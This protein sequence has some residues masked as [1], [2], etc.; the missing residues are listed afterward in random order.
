VAESSQV[1]TLQLWR[2][3]DTGV[4]ASTAS[5]PDLI[6][7]VDCWIN[8]LNLCHQ[9]ICSSTGRVWNPRHNLTSVFCAH[10]ESKMCLQRWDLWCPVCKAW[11]ILFWQE[12]LTC[13]QEGV[14]I[15]IN[16]WFQYYVSYFDSSRLQGM[17]EVLSLCFQTA[18]CVS[19]L[20][21]SHGLRMFSSV[22]DL[23]WAGIAQSV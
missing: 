16:R 7:I 22:T 15:F 12:M 19:H 20:G 13:V 10:K 4:I 3:A 9:N 5:R 14:C 17:L 1:H 6:V 21:L 2:I 11:S 8:V 23:L 18:R